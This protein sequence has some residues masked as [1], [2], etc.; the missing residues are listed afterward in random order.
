MTETVTY[1]GTTFRRYEGRKYFTPGHADRIA[2]VEDLHREV[3]KRE[4]GPIPDGWHVHH[5]D[6]DPSNNDVSNL[7]CLAPP[8]HE[9]IHSADRSARGRTADAQAQLALIRHLAAEWH[10]T[11]AGIAWHRE[12]GAESWK[13]RTAVTYVCDNCGTTYETRSKKGT[14]RFCSNGCRSAA[15]RA[16]GDDLITK[17]CAM[18]SKPYAVNRYSKSST[19][20]PTCRA[21]LRWSKR[22]T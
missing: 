1:Q 20:S 18:C 14:E 16:R 22:T 12:H 11:P 4:R 17:T 19:C 13:R 10:G 7:Q 5:V 8:D 6:F 15:R 3:W 9:A 21:N 2:G